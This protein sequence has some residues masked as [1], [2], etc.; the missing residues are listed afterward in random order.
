MGER[1]TIPAVQPGF[2]NSM[3][4][5]ALMV[6]SKKKPNMAAYGQPE[7]P[8][9]SHTARKTKRDDQQPRVVA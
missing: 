3:D 4:R 6:L 5:G 2:A 1:Y 8:I 9:H 7:G